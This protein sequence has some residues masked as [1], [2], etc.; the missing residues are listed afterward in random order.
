[1]DNVTLLHA[2]VLAGKN[3]INPD[4]FAN[5]NG[6]QQRFGCTRRKLVANLPYAVA[7]PVI[8]NLL[9]SEAAFER[10]VVTVQWE[11]SERLLAGPG[12]KDYGA[13]AVLVQSMA[14]VELVRKPLP[15][16][17]W[18]RPKVASAIVCV[19]PNAA[20]RARVGDV[21]R[22]RVFLRDLYV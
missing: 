3:E 17:F 10:M 2:D 19:R 9:L 12:P 1:R 7:T 8:A 6:L 13:L 21:H 4:V 5:L 11:I 14:D 18:P 22:F 15:A 16:V 20:K